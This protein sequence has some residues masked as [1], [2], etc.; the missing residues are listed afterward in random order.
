V[1]FRSKPVSVHFFKNLHF[2]QQ[3]HEHM[4]RV[5]YVLGTSCKNV[6]EEEHE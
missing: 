2:H 3:A 1:L 4:H 5:V 6:N